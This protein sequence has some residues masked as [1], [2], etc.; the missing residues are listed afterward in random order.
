MEGIT[1]DD[2]A[3]DDVKFFEEEKPEVK[4]EE[5]K[6]EEKEKKPEK[7][8]KVEKVEKIEDE[9]DTFFEETDEDF[10]VEVTEKPSKL[11]ESGNA[12][13]NTLK[14]LKEKEL[15]SFSDEELTNEI[16]DEEVDELLET[17]FEEGIDTRLEDMFE[18]LPEYVKEMNRIALKN[19]D[20]LGYL[21]TLTR[22][23][24][25][26][27]RELDMEEEGD[28]ELIVRKTL[29][30]QGYS[31]DYID[32]QVE[33]LKDTGKLKAIAE[34]EFTKSEKEKDAERKRITK[35]AEDNKKIERE[36]TVKAKRRVSE[37]I[38]KITDVNGI[39]LNKDLKKVLPSY[40]MEK[41]YKLPNGAEISEFQNDLFQAL[42]DQNIALQLAL[43]LKKRDKNGNLDFSFI[44]KEAETTVTKK[45]KE[46]IRRQKDTISA[47]G[48]SSQKKSLADYFN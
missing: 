39:P 9:E 30:K 10:K 29:S 4:P 38:D 28:Q 33:F 18:D 11:T 47:S 20:V 40:I 37:Y 27:D 46:D 8:E 6:P 26:V 12:A 41:T 36:N 19:G 1:L 17:K 5:E 14:F 7:V 32:T 35:Q 2:F 3:W 48:G 42:S 15:I 16:T 45:I 22:G 31:K 23:T 24:Y 21:Q 44:A 25:D 43:L 13:L 34:E